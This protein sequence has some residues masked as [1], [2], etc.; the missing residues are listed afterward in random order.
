MKCL[1]AC[2]SCALRTYFSETVASFGEANCINVLADYPKNFLAI[3]R[4]A[5][6]QRSDPGRGRSMQDDYAHPE[7][8]ET[9]GEANFYQRAG[10]LVHARLPCQLYHERYAAHSA[11]FDMQPILDN[12]SET[13]LLAMSS[14]TS[15]LSH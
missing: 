14:R 12:L 15:L 8:E 4:A 10:R 5:I 11:V 7:R 9:F 6:G 3:Y 13:T 1:Q 2:R